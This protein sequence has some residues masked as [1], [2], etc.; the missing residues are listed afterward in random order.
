MGQCGGREWGRNLSQI[1][2]V[3][4]VGLANYSE[5]SYK[6]RKGNKH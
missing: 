3:E 1:L 6:K 5:A 4:R 2:K